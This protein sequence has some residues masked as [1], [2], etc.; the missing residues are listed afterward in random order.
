LVA[1]K[2]KKFKSLDI[3]NTAHTQI[4]KDR[5]LLLS[6]IAGENTLNKEDQFTMVVEF[7]PIDMTQPCP[8]NKLE[9]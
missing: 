5:V 4:T 2:V 3:K 8:Y 1:F 9:F 7:A 6:I